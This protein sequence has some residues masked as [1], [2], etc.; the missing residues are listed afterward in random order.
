MAARTQS[1]TAAAN[2]APKA[3]KARARKPLYFI[4]KVHGG[5]GRLIVVAHHHKD[6]L[7]ALVTLTPATPPDLVIAGRSNSEF[8]DI[9]MS[10][11][12]AGEVAGGAD[13]KD[14]AQQ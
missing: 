8:L 11:K 14:G 3:R 13:V 9:T 6:A 7:N 5:C 4:A 12:S 2:G 10:T 1:T